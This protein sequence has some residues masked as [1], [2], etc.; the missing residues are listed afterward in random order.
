MATRY[1]LLTLSLPEEDMDLAMGVLSGYPLVG[2]EQGTDEFTICFEQNDWQTDYSETI[3]SEMNGVGLTAVFVSLET[4]EDQNWNA[5]WEASIDPVIVN[6]RIA[7]VPEWRA[8]EFDHPLTLIITPKMSFGTG[9]HATTR[10]MCQLMEQFVQAGDVWID[11][12]TGTGVLGILAA[13]LGATDVYAF[14]NNEWSIANSIEN[15]ARNGV[16]S[17]VRVEHVELQDVVL[18]SCNGLA[19]NLYRHLVIPFA[20][21]FIHAVKPGGVILVSGILKYDKDDVSA[22]F[23]AQGCTIVE[24]LA[25]TEWCAIAFRTPIF[26]T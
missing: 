22:P 4:Q 11:V 12:G 15:V 8:S 16:E 24:S 26:S 17:V 19:A 1:V 20:P 14:D 7:I 18:P 10:M 2:V 13:K 9:H 6:D 25:E 5:E 3:V 23:L 21:S